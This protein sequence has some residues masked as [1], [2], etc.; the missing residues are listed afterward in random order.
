MPVIQR[1]WLN[2]TQ[3][4]PFYTNTDKVLTTQATFP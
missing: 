2:I 1:G 4:M 3:P